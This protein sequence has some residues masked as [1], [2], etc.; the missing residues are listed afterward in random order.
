MIVDI[1]NTDSKAEFSEKLNKWNTEDIKKFFTVLIDQLTS[2]RK[3]L[4]EQ[5]KA[6]MLDI[7][8]DK[9]DQKVKELYVRSL[10]MLCPE[11]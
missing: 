7:T 6:N 4:G 2:D 9:P 11:E 1:L 5:F 10:T 3:E 8:K